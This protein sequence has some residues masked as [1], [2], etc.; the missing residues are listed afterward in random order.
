MAARSWVSRP[1]GLYFGF[2]QWHC[3]VWCATT[4]ILEKGRSANGPARSWKEIAAEVF[5]HDFSRRGG[6]YAAIRRRAVGGFGTASCSNAKIWHR[7]GRKIMLSTGLLVE[8][9]SWTCD[10]IRSANISSPISSSKLCCGENSVGSLSR[11]VARALL[12]VD[13]T[14]SSRAGS[15]DSIDT[16]PARNAD[17]LTLV[18]R[19]SLRTHMHGLREFW[20][21]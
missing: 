20:I 3:S 9:G 4:E 14:G 7:G 17:T 5:G 19:T 18:L 21:F 13:T 1:A 2:L 6:A 16:F 11:L 15:Y 12:S 10:D 8:N